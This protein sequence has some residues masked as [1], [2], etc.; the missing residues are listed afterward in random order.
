MFCV[1]KND[2]LRFETQACR[3]KTDGCITNDCVPVTSQPQLPRFFTKKRKRGCWTL[4]MVSAKNEKKRKEKRTKR[5]TKRLENG[6][7]QQHER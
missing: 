7:K 2:A 5:Q 3:T 1:E 6:V 4:T